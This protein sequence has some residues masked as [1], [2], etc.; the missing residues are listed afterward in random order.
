V[1]GCHSSCRK[2]HYYICTFDIKLTQKQVLI[3][4]RRVSQA[5]F[6]VRSNGVAEINVNATVIPIHDVLDDNIIDIAFGYE[7]FEDFI[8]KQLF[9]MIFDSGS[10]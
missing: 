2:H 10:T 4:A 3:T 5:F 1:V 9:K 7:H 6:M 8:A